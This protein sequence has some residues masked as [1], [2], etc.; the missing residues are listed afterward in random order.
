MQEHED[1]EDLNEVRQNEKRDF[2]QEFDTDRQRM[3]IEERQERE[4]KFLLGK[5]AFQDSMSMDD[6]F[7]EMPDYHQPKD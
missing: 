6:E 2:A 1:N 3:E 5:T 7:D 4:M